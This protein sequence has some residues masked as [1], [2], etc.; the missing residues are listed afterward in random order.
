MPALAV[1]VARLVWNISLRSDIN[2]LHSSLSH[3]RTA[4]MAG[5][6]NVVA[7]PRDGDDLRQPSRPRPSGKT[8]EAWVIPRQGAAPGGH[9]RGGTVTLALRQDATR[10]T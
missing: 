1:V 7:Q 6:G 3:D 8:Y 2:S 10:A 4:T 5:F 9:L